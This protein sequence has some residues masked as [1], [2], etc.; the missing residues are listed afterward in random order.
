MEGTDYMWT[1]KV[2]KKWHMFVLSHFLKDQA[3]NF[4]TQ[5]VATN[6]YSWRL[7]EFFEEMFDYCFPINYRMEQWDKLRQAF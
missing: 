2:E 4:Y 3:Y 7:Q 1:G 5:K 6:P